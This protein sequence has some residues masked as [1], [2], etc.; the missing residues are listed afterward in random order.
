MRLRDKT[1]VVTRAGT[2][3][4]AAN[5]SSVGGFLPVPGQTVYG[6]SRATAKLLT[7]GLNSEL[8]GTNAGVTVALPGAIG[9]DIAASSG[10]PTSRETE[11]QAGAIK[12]LDSSKVAQIILDA[13]ERSR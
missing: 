8:L 5:A 6:A 3:A 4:H 13:I 1:V 12:R 2:E 7:E 11:S 10:V 9:T